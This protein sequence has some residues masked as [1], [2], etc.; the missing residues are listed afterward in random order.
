[1]APM[2]ELGR[3]YVLATRPPAPDEGHAD[4]YMAYL[5]AEGLTPLLRQPRGERDFET[6]DAVVT[7][8]F[9]SPQTWGLELRPGCRADIRFTR[10]VEGALTLLLATRAMPGRVTI[11]ASGPGGPLRQEVYLGSVLALP[12]GAGKTGETAQLTLAVADAQDSVEGFLGLRSFVVL[13]ADDS[14]TEILALQAATD[15]LRQELDFLQNTRSWKLTAPLRRWKG[16]AS[17]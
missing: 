14:A 12:L 7:G 16:R 4:Q 15:A 9:G 17:G 8:T 11:D 2:I 3:E 6:T 10:P 5:Q 13:R 1:M